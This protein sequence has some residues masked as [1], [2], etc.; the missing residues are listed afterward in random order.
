MCNDGLCSMARVSVC[1]I[2]SEAEQINELACAHALDFVEDI[3][4]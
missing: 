2:H 3:H 1:A 4:R